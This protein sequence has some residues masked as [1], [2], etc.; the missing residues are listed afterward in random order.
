MNELPPPS[1]GIGRDKNI[2][3]LELEFEFSAEAPRIFSIIGDEAQ[4]PEELEP[5]ILKRQP[6]DRLIV[7][8]P[9]FTRIEFKI[10]AISSGS[11]VTVL[12]DLIKSVEDHKTFRKIWTTWFKQI[13]KRVSP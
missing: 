1:P 2:R 4:W 3:Q 9:D 10:E 6:N 8:L 12:H 13:E 7:A 11:R 5:R